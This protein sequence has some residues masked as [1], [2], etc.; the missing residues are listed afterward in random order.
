MISFSFLGQPS[1]FFLGAL[2][3]GLTLVCGK[4]ECCWSGRSSFTGEDFG[5]N[6]PAPAAAAQV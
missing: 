1:F 2:S 3:G 5:G 4:W 6:L